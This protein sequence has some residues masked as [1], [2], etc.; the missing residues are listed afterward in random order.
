MG[1][2]LVNEK[3]ISLA[4]YS[5]NLVFIPCNMNP[6]TG[7]RNDLQVQ[8]PEFPSGLYTHIL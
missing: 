8:R 2:S 7:Y 6:E 4:N 3:G 5:V 1:A